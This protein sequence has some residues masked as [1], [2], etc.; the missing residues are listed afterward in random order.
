MEASEAPIMPAFFSLLSFI[1]VTMPAKTIMKPIAMGAQV[2][3]EGV[4]FCLLLGDVVCWLKKPVITSRTPRMPAPQAQ[5]I[6][7]FLMSAIG[8]F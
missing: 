1:S 2:Y 7:W 8:V 4:H 3:W 6:G 5:V